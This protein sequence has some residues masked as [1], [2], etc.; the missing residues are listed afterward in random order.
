MQVDELIVFQSKFN[1][2]MNRFL[3]EF[4]RQFKMRDGTNAISS[5]AQAF[6]YQF[7]PAFIRIHAFLRESN[8]LDGHDILQ[9]VPEFQQGFEGSHGRI[10]H[11]SMRAD[12]LYAGCHFFPHGSARPCFDLVKRSSRFGL[13]PALDP[14]KERSG[15]IGCTFLTGR[16]D[17]IQ[18][19]MRIH[20]RRSHQFARKI[21]DLRPLCLQVR[22]NPGK[23][24]IFHQDILKGFRV[25]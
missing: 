2:L 7:I 12:V 23:P 25:L 5:H 19:D 9:F 17:I 4:P 21:N 15:L 3:P 13:T 6:F 20:V 18:M 8:D 24:A 14:L 10:R 16:V 22:A 1:G 11:V